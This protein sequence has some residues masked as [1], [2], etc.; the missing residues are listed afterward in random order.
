MIGREDMGPRELAVWERLDRVDDP[1]LDQPIT[2]LGFVEEVEVDGGT[3]A[4]TFRLPT[5][6]C[7]PNFAFLMAEGIREEVSALGW[8]RTVRV[9]LEDHLCGDELNAAV[10]EGKS[11]AEV[12]AAREEGGDLA[13]VRETFDRK[14]LQRRQEAVLLAL[15]E[16]GFAPGDVSA[17]TLGDLDRIVF[18]DPEAAR[19]KRRYREVL[20]RRG[21]VT[22][23]D[24]HAFP[25]V[26]GTPLTAETYR[27]RMGR[28][29]GVRINMEFGSVFCR[30]LKEVRYK[31]AVAVDG[32]W[33]L[34]DFMRGDVPAGA[35]PG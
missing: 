35:A 3:V 15:R 22:A 6:W 28:L 34:V 32:E 2:E 29:R 8:V 20:V 4:V 31:E 18:D 14:A 33:T 11:F 30:G 13:E 24:D 19:Q 16:M 26:D 12:F 10:N 7:S 5:Y 23:G 9:R 21:L 1:E 25:D 27:E 17:M